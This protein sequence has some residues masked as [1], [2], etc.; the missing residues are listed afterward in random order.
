MC[1]PSQ[2]IRQFLATISAK[3]QQIA[4]SSLERKRTMTPMLDP[5]KPAQGSV[6]TNQ[7]DE[8]FGEEIVARFIARA[9]SMRHDQGLPDLSVGTLEFPLSRNVTAGHRADA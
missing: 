8:E 4:D 3:S 9:N 5:F 7:N 1:R 6:L 2:T